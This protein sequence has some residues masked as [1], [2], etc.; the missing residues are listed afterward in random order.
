MRIDGSSTRAIVNFLIAILCGAALLLI[1]LIGSG[2]DIDD[3]SARAIGTAIA[4]AFFSLTGVAGTNLGQRRP[5]LAWF[6]Y[7]AAAVSAI[8]LLMMLGAIW[9]GDF[10][11]DNWKPAVIALIFAFA[12]GHAS[13]L[14]TPALEDETLRVVR[15]GTILTLAVL[16][17]TATAAIAGNEVGPQPVG[18]VAVLYAL[19]TIVLAL[20]RR[21]TPA[22]GR[23]ASAP[24][25]DG[26]VDHLPLDHL[27]LAWNGTA[28]AAVEHLRQRGIEPVMGP[29]P[30][31]GN[32]GGGQSV[33]YRGSDGSLIELI[34]Y[35]R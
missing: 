9:S 28:D 24:G 12:A 32:G 8:A 7:L 16:V 1:V 15:N 30:G 33:Y 2:S 13:V 18:V 25:T 34:A 6:G 31:T 17:L 29:V 3:D 10:G 14:L 11:N 26:A 22:A 20:L 27:C 23:P 21:T 4:I 35:R 5:E 19:G